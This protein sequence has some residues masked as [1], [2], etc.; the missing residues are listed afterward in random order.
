MLGGCGCCCGNLPPVC[1]NG[2]PNNGWGGDANGCA[3]SF[4]D[5]PGCNNSAPPGITNVF[6]IPF[7][8]G[9]GVKWALL[10]AGSNGECLG[11]MATN[12]Y[13]KSDGIDSPIGTYSGYNYG[14]Y[15]NNAT[16][17]F[18]VTEKLEESC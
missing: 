12:F 10:L 7:L 9:F 8:C 3:S 4:L 15:G 16:L 18:T 13:C 6:W 11:N 14:Y 2:Y 5:I 17:T 1:L